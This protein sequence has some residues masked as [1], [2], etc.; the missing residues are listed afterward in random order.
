M[1]RTNIRFATFT[2]AIIS[3]NTTAPNKTSNCFADHC[4]IAAEFLLPQIVADEC[5]RR[6]LSP[7]MRWGEQTS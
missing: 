5:R 6:R 7:I 2:Q 4:G 3:T 1:A